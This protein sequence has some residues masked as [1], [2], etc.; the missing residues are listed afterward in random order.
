MNKLLCFALVLCACEKTNPYYCKD[1]PDHNCT[2]DGTIAMACTSPAQCTEQGK[3][4]C[5]LSLGGGTCVQCSAADHTACI[6]MMPVCGS[7]DACHP[8]SAHSDCGANGACLPDGSCGSDA[9]VSWVVNPGGS[10]SNTCS[11]AMPCATITTALTKSKSFI[12]VTGTTKDNVTI[13]RSVTILADASGDL[14]ANNFGNVLTIG[15][16]GITVEI[17]D[18]SITGGNGIGVQIPQSATV[19]LKRVTVAH[20]SNIGVNASG[21][22]T[23]NVWRSTI[24]FNNAGGISLQGMSFDI[25][26]NFIYSNGGGIGFGG[27]SVYMGAASQK[28][29]FN[30]ITANLGPGGTST[31]VQ[32][33][34]VSPTPTFA[35]D[36]I[37]GNVVVTGVPQASAGCNYAYSNMGPN[38]TPTG[39]N[40]DTPPQFKGTSDFHIATSSPMK[41]AADPNATLGND[42]DGDMR[43]IDMR[44]DIGADETP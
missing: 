30:T 5:D 23:L 12:K 7:D 8:C 1:N 21:G 40:L 34:A 27:V 17:D 9:N 38:D 28:L 41:N 10:D 39:T 33:A 35:N 42:I 29:D 15:A 31:G 44:R 4:V 16:A 19:T 18:L 26:N 14:A 6:G 24:A 36:I 32:C 43:P 22:G 3:L 25:E 37:Y 2:I 11:Q 20:N 13:N